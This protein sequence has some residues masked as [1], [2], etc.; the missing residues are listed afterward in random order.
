MTD[1]RA[2]C[3]ELLQGLDENRHPEVR[4]PGHL[5]IIMD[6]ARTA[7]AQP[8]PAG[9]VMG[10][11]LD[12]ELDR[13]TRVADLPQRQQPV[14]VGER[15]PEPSRKVLAHYFNGLGK[16]RTICAIWVP[17]KSRSDD[18]DLTDDDFQEYD[19]ESDKYYWPEGWYEAIENWDDYGWIKVNEGEPVYWQPL[20]TWPTPTTPPKVP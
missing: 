8:E 14:A 18:L 11:E 15:L 6:R 2:L 13:F 9:E 10:E 20:P 1:Y 19:E 12:K 7:L 5:R 16:G 3:A 17:A 4:Y